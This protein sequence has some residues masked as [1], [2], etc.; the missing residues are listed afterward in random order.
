M[1]SF[2]AFCTN[3]SHRPITPGNGKELSYKVLVSLASIMS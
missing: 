2:T 1:Y 3:K